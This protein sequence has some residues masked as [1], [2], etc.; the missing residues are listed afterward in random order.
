MGVPGAGLGQWEERARRVKPW[1]ASEEVLSEDGRIACMITLR[2]HIR[3]D[4]IWQG[5]SFSERGCEGLKESGDNKGREKEDSE[6]RHRLRETDC[7]WAEP[8]ES[9][10]ISFLVKMREI[11]AHL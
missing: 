7:H 3:G 5:G 2:G 8:G 10:E 1:K 4:W 9:R 11:I 6:K